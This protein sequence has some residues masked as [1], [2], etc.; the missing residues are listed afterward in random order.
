MLA[1]PVPPQMGCVFLCEA[2]AAEARTKIAASR[3]QHE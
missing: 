2:D 1:Y 3:S